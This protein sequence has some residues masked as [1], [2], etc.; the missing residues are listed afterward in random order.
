MTG[1]VVELELAAGDELRVHPG[2]L[3]LFDA[4]IS[5]ELTTVPGIKNKIFGGDGLFLARLTGQGKVW[6]Q[7]IS[8]A[9]LAAALQPYLETEHNGEA[10]TV[11]GAAGVLGSL[12]KK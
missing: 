2:H 5:V 11:G 4:T 12:L 8:I 9:A 3:A 7:S 10:A 6:L 1:D